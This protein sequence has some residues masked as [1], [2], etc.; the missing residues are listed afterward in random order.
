MK[1]T[2]STF[3]SLLLLLLTLAVFSCSEK[4][5]TYSNKLTLGASNVDQLLDPQELDYEAAKIEIENRLET[6]GIDEYKVE[7]VGEKEDKIQISY[8][9]DINDEQ[10]DL[11]LTPPVDIGIYATYD[12]FEVLNA[13]SIE[14]INKFLEEK[15]QLENPNQKVDSL[16]LANN[17]NQAH[18]KYFPLIIIGK[19]DYSNHE[20][21][22]GHSNP[23]DTSKIMKVLKGKV[24]SE[25]MTDLYDLKWAWG[26]Q[27]T[28]V[29]KGEGKVLP[30]YAT[31]IPFDEESIMTGKH[32]KKAEAIVSKETGEA[33]LSIEMTDKGQELFE[34]LTME[35]L[36]KQ[37]VIVVNNQVIQAPVVN[38]IISSGKLWISGGYNLEELETI[39]DLLNH[40][41]LPFELDIIPNEN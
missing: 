3:S 1:N 2:S 34:K 8:N 20:A 24:V 14:V 25:A 4:E 40:A 28:Q 13:L 39:A 30:L 35:N 9:G 6:I 5:I 21:V 36:N 18:Q 33:T 38:E 22:F 37:V 7:L 17:Y 32:I 16:F 15:L 19:T 26:I 23:K 29:L 11:L 41:Y 10:L 12:F 27:A 31:R